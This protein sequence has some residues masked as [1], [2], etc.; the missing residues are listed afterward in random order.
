MPR[1]DTCLLNGK[2]VDVTDAL[3]LRDDARKRRAL[4]L[5]FRCTNCNHTVRPHKDS[6]YGA[7]HFEHHRR[8]ADC[9]LSAPDPSQRKPV[10]DRR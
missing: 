3:R 5:D 7:A 8:N 4:R 2:L 1:A 6:I 9:K 10:S